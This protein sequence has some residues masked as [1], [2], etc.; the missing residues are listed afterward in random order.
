MRLGRW[1]SPLIL[2]V[3]DY[4]TIVCGLLS[5]HFFRDEMIAMLV[6]GI[7]PFIV[8]EQ[9]YFVILP[10]VFLVFTL[11]EKL[12]TKRLP[13]W[14]SIELLF[15]VCTYSVVVIVGILFFAGEAKEISRLAVFF[16]WLFVFAYLVGA[17][18]I[19]KRLLAK[20]GLWQKPVVLVGAGKTAE[21]LSEAFAN[22]PN[23][24][25]KIIGVIEDHYQG[26]S[27]LEKYPLLGNF[28]NL[29]QAIVAS[30]VQDV[31]IAAPGLERESLLNVVYRVQPLV[32][33]VSLVPNLFGIPLGNLE[34]EALFQQKALVLR[35]RNNLARG[36]NRLFKY[37]MDILLTCIGGLVLI[38]VF[39]IISL[40]IYLDSPGPVIFSH[41]RIGAD[42][43]TF[44]CYKFRTMVI[45]A[46]A[47]LSA[48]LN[49]NPEAKAEWERDFKLKDDPR[50]TR[51]GKWLR[52]TSLDELPQLLNVL[53]GEM[54]LVGPRPIVQAEIIKY[55]DYINDYYLVRPG[56]TG[57]WQVN[58][59]SDVDYENRVQ[60]DSWYVRN[61]SVW[62]DMVLLVQTAK[63]VVERKGAY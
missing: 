37:S 8:S 52:K 56:I 14:Q 32:N 46:E 34:A 22:D 1:L 57:Y 29:E 15:K 61:W 2:F 48:Y 31:L 23:M 58:G 36:Y 17:R 44:P 54:S 20:C 11:Y 27:M 3:L 12:Y 7:L 49:S 9:Y 18:F 39:A 63:I 43:S 50:V 45:D 53:R 62:L 42:G 38:P 35:I 51:I 30:G 41:R 4:M 40:L 13:L 47:R 55:G 19:A 16:S 59:R 24:G 60:M 6:P 5:A 10:S 25:Y 26:K 33:N 21:L 28:A